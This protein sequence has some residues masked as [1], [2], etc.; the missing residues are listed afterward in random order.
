MK[1]R[2]DLDAAVRDYLERPN[3]A[4][5][6]MA[7]FAASV[8]GVLN[9]ELRDHPRNFRRGEWTA[10]DNTGLIPIP[11]DMASLQRVMDAKGDLF[12][13]Y[14]ASIP[15]EYRG[16]INRG[17]VLQIA[18][19]PAVGDVVRFDY[20]GYLP[21]LEFDISTNWV[22][23]HH[24][25][26]YL[27][28]CLRE[29]AVFYRETQNLALWNTEFVRRVEALRIQGWNQNMANAPKVRHG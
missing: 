10:E 23:E 29:A 14:P 9:R 2:A 6:S 12:E 4:D 22:L 7:A 1:T 19:A 16:Y 18:P 27:Y 24:F 15:P 5:T 20:I 17:T 28:G 21:A 11:G 25:D 3:L 8:E 26:V 13:Q